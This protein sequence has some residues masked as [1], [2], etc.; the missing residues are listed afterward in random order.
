MKHLNEFRHTGTIDAQRLAGD[1]E[2]FLYSAEQ[3]AYADARGELRDLIRTRRRARGRAQLTIARD[4]GLAV[5]GLSI[6]G[7]VGNVAGYA[8]LAVTAWASIQ[9][10][11]RRGD[12]Y[13]HGYAVGRALPDEHRLLLAHPDN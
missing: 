8:G 2:S 10:L 13:R 3:I 1:L 11:R 4:L 9:A 5:A 7:L 12:T 6:W